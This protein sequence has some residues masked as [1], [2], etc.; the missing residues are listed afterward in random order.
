MRVARSVLA[1]ILALF[2]SG[3]S[4]WGRVPEAPVEVLRLCLGLLWAGGMGG[5]SSLWLPIGL[6]GTDEDGTSVSGVGA[7]MGVNGVVVE[8]EFAL[9][10]VCTESGFVPLPVLLAGTYAALLA[11]DH[12]L[13]GIA[14][15]SCDSGGS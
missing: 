6:T 5:N 4:T 8:T 11:R 13:G 3:F 12:F 14:G 1:A 7:D 10:D 9:N 2:L 15:N